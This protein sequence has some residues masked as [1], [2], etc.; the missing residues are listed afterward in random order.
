MIPPIV[1]LPFFHSWSSEN[2]T[3][4]PINHSLRIFFPRFNFVNSLIQNGIMEIV[5]IVVTMRLVNINI[6]LDIDK[7]NNAINRG[8]FRKKIPLSIVGFLFLQI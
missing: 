3:A 8:Y 1:G 2:S 7:S 5:R 4:F 6:R